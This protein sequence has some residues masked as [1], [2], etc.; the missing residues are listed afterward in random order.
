MTLNSIVADILLYSTDFGSF[1]SF[2]D[3]YVKV[4]DDTRPK[5]STAKR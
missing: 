3:N 4:I 1:D 2:V 5:L